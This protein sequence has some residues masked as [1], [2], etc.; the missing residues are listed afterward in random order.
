[1]QLHHREIETR[2][3]ETKI[4]ECLVEVQEEFEMTQ[5]EF[6][7][8]ITRVLSSQ[9]NTIFKYQLRMERHGNTETPADT[10]A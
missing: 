1:M 7:R 3:A 4:I 6:G 8:L 9:L 5:A 10:E 2:G